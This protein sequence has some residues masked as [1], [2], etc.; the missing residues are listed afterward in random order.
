MPKMQIEEFESH[1]VGDSA[2]DSCA[3]CFPILCICGGLI[4]NTFFDESRDSVYYHYQCDICADD[5]EE[6]NPIPGGEIKYKDT[7][8]RVN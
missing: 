4:H 5:Y 7:R 3:F 1:E 8:K 2:C 6:A